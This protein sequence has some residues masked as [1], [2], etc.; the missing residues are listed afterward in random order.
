MSIERIAALLAKAASGN[1]SAMPAH[2]ALHAATLG[3]A[4]AL[5][6]DGATGS[7][8]AGKW[9][10]LCAVEIAGPQL[11]PVYDVAS[12]LVYAV[13]RENVTD[14]WV[15]GMP[16]LAS[17]TLVSGAFR[18]LDKRVEM[19]QNKLAAETRA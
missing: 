18:D 2:A 6:L 5:G 11:A 4:R 12:H 15:A 14:V 17:R 1:A 3:G 9:A 19:W 7:L 8:V 16:V 10:D 13:G